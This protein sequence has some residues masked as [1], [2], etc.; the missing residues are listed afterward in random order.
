MPVELLAKAFICCP[1]AVRK[2]M[3]SRN[4]VGSTGPYGSLAAS[5]SLLTLGYLQFA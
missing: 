1:A 5:S 2:L 3:R 4:A